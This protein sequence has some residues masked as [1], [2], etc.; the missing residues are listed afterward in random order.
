MTKRHICDR[1]QSFNLGQHRDRA[2]LVQKYEAMRTD[3][4]VFLRGTCHLFYQD[5]PVK[6][7]FKK[8]PLVWICGDLH[9]ENFGSYKSDKRH[10]Y[11]DVN[12]FDE[13]ILAPCTWDVVRFVT[14]VL[15][16][17]RTVNIQMQDAEKLCDRFLTAYSQALADGKAYWVGKDNAE[18]IIAALLARKN[19]E[20][21]VDLL[22]K[23]TELVDGERRIKIDPKRSRPI[24]D[25]QRQKIEKW[26]QE[27]AKLQTDSNFF[28]LLDAAQR[29]AG[30]GSLGI[31]RYILL[32]EGKGSPNRNYLL[33]LKESV[34][35]SLAPYSIWEQPKWTTEA[36]RIVAVQ[37]SNQ[38]VAIAFLDSA[39]IAEKSYV[40]REL[41][42][43]QSPTDRLKLEQ[44]DDKLKQVD[45]LMASLGKTVAWSQLR[46]SGRKGAAI[47]DDLIDFANRDKWL[48]YVM[49]YAKEYRKTVEDDWAEFK[50]GCDQ[51]LEDLKETSASKVRFGK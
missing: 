39:T 36:E 51:L 6:S 12:D 32:V 16:A 20:T 7:W 34:R 14:S 35:S 15:V 28:K 40:L 9:I 2:L 17:A 22:E 44:W 8:A 45:E 30:T 38:A 4:F 46:S 5:L 10:L 21:R 31:D 1:I 25:E 19:Q 26:M 48:E 18:G 47:A 13:A 11:F 41:Q 27:F 3:A 29:S 50:N 43:V 49:D 37:T 33:D 23:R 24:S 42:S